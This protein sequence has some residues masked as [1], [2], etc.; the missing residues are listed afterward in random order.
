MARRASPRTSVK[1]IAS[2][3]RSGDQ[4]GPV[5][6]L[7]HNVAHAFSFGRP[8]ALLGASLLVLGLVA[9]LWSG[10]H[11][12]LVSV[13]RSI[14]GLATN[15]SFGISA[16]HLSGNRYIAPDVILRTLGFAPGQS[17]FAADVQGARARLLKLDWLADAEVTRRYPDSIYVRLVEKAPFAVWNSGNGAAVVD[18]SGHPIA[19]IDSSRFSKL[20]LFVGD[21]PEGAS[22]LVDSINLHHAISAR[23]RAMQRVS[24]RRWNL[25]LDDG[26]LVKLPEQ[27]WSQQLDALE[28]LIV[29]KGILERD[30]AEIDL[31]SPANYFFVLRNTVRRKLARGSRA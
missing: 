21:R 23:V 9:V 19:R 18:R 30:I 24:G 15:A 5:S 20:P 12:A 7:L 13:H 14:S 4:N 6:R 22:E 17:I 8:F 29:D 31:R 10:G 25:I 1:R 27:N 3:S 26:V 11:R 28:R 16:I 2:R